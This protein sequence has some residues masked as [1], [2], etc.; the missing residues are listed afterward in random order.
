MHAATPNR[1]FDFL[2]AQIIQ[3][4]GGPKRSAKNGAGSSG[5]AAA[6][7]RPGPDWLKDAIYSPG[8][9][10]QQDELHRQIRDELVAELRPEGFTQAATVDALASDYLQLAR[11]RAMA[12][13]L[14][15]PAL[16]REDAEICTLVAAK[17]RLHEVV[18]L[19]LE[20]GG[21]GRGFG[22]TQEQGEFLAGRVMDLLQGIQ[23]NVDQAD[24]EAAEAEEAPLQ[25]ES[26]GEPTATPPAGTKAGPRTEAEVEAEKTHLAAL[27]A[28]ED[29]DL[30]HLRELLALVA[31]AKR[32]FAD[33]RYVTAVFCGTQRPTRG[34]PERLGALLKELAANVRVALGVRESSMQRMR[35]LVEERLEFVARHPNELMIIERHIAGIESAIG[36][37]LKALR[38][39]R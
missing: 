5:P 31:P 29:E 36:R 9:A 37:K 24:A 35:R 6:R 4:A 1:L 19:A 30:S 32:R 21:A 38:P 10:G 12:V 15:R 26:D 22:C 27:P 39:K 13:A 20:R 23:A 2:Q 34:D 25:D 17:Q 16:S 11:L 28:F 7:A 8:D 3:P 18:T 33:H 14:Q